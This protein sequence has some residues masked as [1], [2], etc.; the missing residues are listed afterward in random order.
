MERIGHRG[1]ASQT[2]RFRYCELIG[3]TDVASEKSALTQFGGQAL[4]P[5]YASPEQVRGE[6]ISTASDVYSLGVIAYEMLTDTKP[7]QL[8]RQPSTTLGE[9]VATVN[10]KAASAAVADPKV[11]TQLKG[12]IDAILNK[13]LKKEVVERY[14]TVDALADDIERH[15]ANLPVQAQPDAV[16]YRLRKF[17]SRNKL[18]VIAASVTSFSLVAGL[19]GA[20]WQARVAR[21]EAARAE[22]VKQFIASIFTEAVPRQG[23][24][25]AVTATDLLSAAAVRIEK[26]L[27]D[28]PRVAAELGVLIGESFSALGEP[29]KGEATLKAAVARAE[30][31]YGRQHRLTIH[32]KWL[33]VESTNNQDLAASERLLAEV[34][35][36][37]LSGLPATAKDAVEALAQQSF[38][39]AKRNK[40]EE[41]YAALEQSIA[42][43]EK[44]LGP[45]HES[46]LSSLGLLSNTYARFGDVERQWTSASEAM[47]RATLAFGHSRP[48]VTL[49]E[50]ERW[51]ADALTAKGRPGDAVLILKRVLHDQR[52]LDGAETVRVRHAMSRLARALD[53]VGGV[54]RVGIDAWGLRHGGRA[55][56][57]RIRRPG[58]K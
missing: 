12:D 19:S 58:P 33:L 50:V 14:L 34:V 31:E 48:H 7:Y 23:V 17:A 49:A 45:Q 57:D 9:A 6:A 44:Y 43:G 38:L 56:P 37:A 46:T 15:L 40:A 54:E 21:I 42:V 11:K 36:D 30:R 13:A 16:G 24:G 47:R 41:S 55:G 1:R 51:Y 2:A 18:A 35:P 32:G 27:A 39:L 8:K 29:A 53:R 25:G 26:Q 22:Q 5:D 4:T 28:S 20:I 3:G 52:A 10:I